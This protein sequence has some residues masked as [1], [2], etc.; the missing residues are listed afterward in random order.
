MRKVFFLLVVAL[1][2]GGGWMT[3]QHYQIEGLEYL[4][5]KPRGATVPS[6][7]NGAPP[8]ERQTDTIRIGSFNIQAFGAAKL[9]KPR[10]ANILADIVRRFDVV[11]IQAIRSKTDDLLPRF[12]EA[13]NSTGRHYDYAIGPRLGRTDS[14]EQYAFIFDT[15]SIEVDRNALYTVDDPDDL[16]HREPLVGWFRVRGPPENEAFTFKLI[17]IHTDPDQTKSELD[18]LADVYR[19]VR[20]DG[21]GEDDV[22]LLGDLNADDKH[23]GRLGEISN[24][25]AVISGVPTNTRGT[26][27]SDNMIFSR[28]AT[29]EYTG[30]SGVFDMIREYNLTMNEALEVSDHMPIWAEFTVREGGQPGRVAKRQTE[31]AK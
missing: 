7:P 23:L 8:V 13:V 12:M 22:I 27:Q 30:R 29:V 24:L 1:L 6:D 16:L 11:A 18:A 19:A 31:T 10:V 3:L 2:A 4:K 20:D 26:R 14:K 25:T 9:N 17:D 15:A 5:L 28:A 21:R